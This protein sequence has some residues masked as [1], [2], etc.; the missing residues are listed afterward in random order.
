MAACGL[1]AKLDV[2][3]GNEAAASALFLSADDC[4]CT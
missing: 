1:F 3:E 2:T 4:R